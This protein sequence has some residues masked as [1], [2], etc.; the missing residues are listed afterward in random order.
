MCVRL[1]CICAFEKIFNDN[2]T[3]T[4]EQE[5]RGE[6]RKKEVGRSTIVQYRAWLCMP[7]VGMYALSLVRKRN[8]WMNCT[9]EWNCSLCIANSR[10]TGST[11]RII[12][13]QEKKERRESTI[14]NSSSKRFWRRISSS[15]S[16]RHRLSLF[17]SLCAEQFCWRNAARIWCWWV[18]C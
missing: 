12:E 9:N 6:K 13:I 11:E 4:H 14:R 10:R 8:V 18:W 17:S 3:H 1:Q 7:K 2:R 15:N 5:K 16:N